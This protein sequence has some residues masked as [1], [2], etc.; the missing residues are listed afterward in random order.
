MD[1]QTSLDKKG[2]YS[3]FEE[4]TDQQHKIQFFIETLLYLKSMLKRVLKNTNLSYIP[5]DKT[6]D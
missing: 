5:L 6:F 4:Y 3:F 2:I 1:Q